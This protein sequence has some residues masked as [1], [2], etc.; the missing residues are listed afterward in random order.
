[1]SETLANQLQ[2]LLLVI[3]VVLIAALLRQLR[4][5]HRASTLRFSFVLRDIQ[6][7]ERRLDQVGARSAGS[8][9]SGALSRTDVP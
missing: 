2:V 6:E 5:M 4:I 7:A 1:M 3:L 9:S 8:S